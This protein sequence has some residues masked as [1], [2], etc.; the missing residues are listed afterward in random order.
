MKSI[1]PLSKSQLGIYA[2]C[3]QHE[4]EVFYNLPF[5]YIFDGSIDADRLC[6]AIEATVQ[7]HPVFFTRIELS[8][9]G[10]P[11]QTIDTDEVS[12]FRFQILRTLRQRRENLSSLSNSTEVGC[13][14]PK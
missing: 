13:F 14:I 9:E 10:E 11:L 6:R 3:V 5:L 2:E 12:G 4:N 1:A 8:D 7:A